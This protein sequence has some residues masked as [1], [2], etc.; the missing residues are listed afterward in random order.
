MGNSDIYVVK[1]DTAFNSVISNILYKTY[2]KI[3]PNP[4]NNYL[5]INFEKAIQDA[6]I[7]LYNTIGQKVLQANNINNNI[8]INVKN[9]PEGLY[10][11][12]I[13]IKG[14]TEYSQKI[15]IL[16]Y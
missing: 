5:Q 13:N 4:A 11:I 12:K 3:F 1:L 10:M 9:I 7:S 2:I 16:H 15:L 8:I 14:E 6:N